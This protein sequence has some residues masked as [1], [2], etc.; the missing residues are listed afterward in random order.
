MDEFSLE[1][2]EFD[3]L[4]DVDIQ[5][6]TGYFF[7]FGKEGFSHAI[8]L[9]TIAQRGGIFGRKHDG[10]LVRSLCQVAISPS[11]SP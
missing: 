6:P 2:G 7:L 5:M 4:R 8:Q 11:L 1:I 9:L 3:G 10:K